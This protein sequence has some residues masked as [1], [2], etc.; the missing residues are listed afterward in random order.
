MKH[1]SIFV[2]I[3]IFPIIGFAQN[4]NDALIVF[5]NGYIRTMNIQNK[6][7]T[8][9]GSYYY[10]DN[11]YIG[12]LELFSGEI[13]NDYPLKLDL[14]FNQIDIKVNESVK[15]ITAGAIKEIV[16]RNS[17]GSIEVLRNTSL[18]KDFKG[19]N[20]FFSVLVEGNITLM[21]KM[22]LTLLEGNY[23]GAID[24]G[25]ENSKYVKK[26]KYYI[27]KDYKINKIRKSRRIVS[28]LLSDQI[29]KIEE[30]VDANNLNLKEED[31]LIRVFD[32][33]NSL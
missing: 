31:D 33:Y 21:K 20:G 13:I 22:E 19:S 14:K 28:Q 26:E 3:S 7:T 6:K 11:W 25:N 24:A 29:T 1:I 17:L 16:W 18:Y 8:T 5:S 15:I 27:L 23:N 30:F 10:N 32:Y 2:F 9:E 4:P 12:K